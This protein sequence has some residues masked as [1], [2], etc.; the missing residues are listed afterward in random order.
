MSGPTALAARGLV[1]RRASKRSSFELR[2]DALDLH[3][4][5][6]LAVLGPNGAGKSTLLRTLAGL[7][8]PLSGTLERRVDGPVTMVF[9]RPVAFAGT[10]AQNVAV[11]LSGLGL[12]RGERE[13][14]AGEALEHFDIARLARRRASTLSGGELRRLALAR[15]FA[16]RP[17][18]LLLDEPFD[19]L[20]PAGQEALSLDLRRAIG[21]TR[22]A[23]AVVTHDLRRALLLADRVAVL[24][25]GRLVQEGE[26]EEVLSQPCDLLV[27]RLVGMTNLIEGVV[28]S[29]GVQ[30]DPTLRRVE[31]DAQHHLPVATGLAP[32]TRVWAGIRPERLKVDV[33]RGEGLPVGKGVVQSVVSD[34]VAVT[35]QVLWAG[36]ELRTH[37]LA[38]RGLARTIAPGDSVTLSVRPTDT[39]LLPA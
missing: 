35:V 38:G 31:V 36:H 1:V 8:S 14:R 29:G 4:G 12:A 17:A 3:A 7:E 5:G 39:H 25:D 16:L 24:M 33:G 32:G 23:L 10:V 9:Q 15:A 27:A 6:V 26:R 28:A 13:G 2:V 19:D 20:D 22:V 30:G 37:L 34:G 21:T 18:V 11:A